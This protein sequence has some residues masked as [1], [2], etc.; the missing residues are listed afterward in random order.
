M[1]GLR[2]NIDDIDEEIRRK[3][4]ETQC[5]NI[6][7]VFCSLLRG[8][9]LKR[10]SFSNP[11]SSANLPSSPPPLHKETNGTVRWSSCPHRSSLGLRLAGRP[12]PLGNGG[13]RQVEGSLYKPES[14]CLGEKEVSRPWILICVFRPPRAALAE[15]APASWETWFDFAPG[16]PRAEFPARQSNEKR[17][18]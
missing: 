8:S 15:S 16:A 1:K 9:L 12:Q 2:S 14:V 7:S 18:N 10:G 5:P 17:C 11:G 4:S 6:L 3:G 13:N